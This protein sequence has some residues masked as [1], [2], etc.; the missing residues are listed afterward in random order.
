MSAGANNPLA[1]AM[2]VD[3]GSG[4]AEV[5]F[6]DVMDPPVSPIEPE[7][8]PRQ[9]KRGLK[10]RAISGGLWTGVSFGGSQALALLSN[11][12]LSRLL[13]PEHFGLMTLVTVIVTGLNMF[14][15]VGIGPSLIQNKREDAGFY[16][17]AWTMQVF[18]GF[19]LWLV[20]CGLA[21]PLSLIKEDWAPLAWLLPVA[22]ITCIFNGL[23]STAW[24]TVS[25]RLDIRLIAVVELTTA[26]VRIVTMVLVA[27]YISRS[28]WALVAGLLIGS[29]LTCVL[30]HRMIPEIKNRIHFERDAFKEL[31]HFGKWLFLSTLI[32][33]LAGQV[34]K[35]LIGGLIST[36]M[37]GLYFI[38]SRLADLGPMFFKKL[39]VWVGFPALSELY[40]N[41]PERFGSQLLKMRMVIT[42]PI[43][44]LLV[45]MILTGP[46]LVVLMFNDEYVQAG[47]LVQII[48]IGSLAGM[49][50]TPYGHVYMAS[51][52]TKYNML[53]VLA[54]FIIITTATLSGYALFGEIGFFY[55]IGACQ[56]LKYIADS[57]LVH[58]CGHWQWRF[59]FAVLGGSLALG[60]LAWWL[61]PEVTAWAHQVDPWL[62]EQ[63]V[64]FKQ[65]VKGGE[66]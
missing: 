32:T 58:R 4:L 49:V 22:A 33:F 27:F 61:S 11:I 16:N 3:T 19:V 36:S 42:L 34:D 51:G 26:V 60:L 44:A 12:I 10:Q 48:A 2:S 64:S 17:T 40:R 35:F 24:F 23:R 7:P 1:N 25:R 59:D 57:V 66:G 14:S 38:A 8:E 47:L 50:T 29:L 63:F 41:E 65:W 9:E 43:N 55:G 52:R 31:I 18:R 15:D 39:G 5:E 45:C 20:A 62:T 56:W 46:A 37:L 54:Q 28:A 6:P 53:S 13:V 21:W 30:S